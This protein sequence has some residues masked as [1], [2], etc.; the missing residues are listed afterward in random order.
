MKKEQFLNETTNFDTSVDL[1]KK[2]G[3]TMCYQTGRSVF[4]SVCLFFF[5]FSLSMKSHMLSTHIV[6]LTKSVLPRRRVTAIYQGPAL[7]SLPVLSHHLTPTL[8]RHLVPRS[9]TRPLF[10]LAP[11]I[12]HTC[13]F[14]SLITFFI[15]WFPLPLRSILQFSYR[16]SFH[17]F[18]LFFLSI[19]TFFP[20]S[21][22]ITR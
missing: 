15:C 9:L 21:Y 10:D 17:L 20:L 4:V 19:M 18:S 2:Y 7:L 1:T 11:V 5:V 22:R 14:I 8:C 13:L 16:L 3:R 6:T 12:T